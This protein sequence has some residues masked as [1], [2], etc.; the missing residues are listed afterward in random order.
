MYQQSVLNVSHSLANAL[1]LSTQTSP[2]GA[3]K[4]YYF[5]CFMNGD[6]KCLWEPRSQMHRIWFLRVFSHL[7][8][9]CS[10][11]W[12]CTMLKLPCVFKWR[13]SQMLVGSL[14]Q[15]SM[16][17]TSRQQ[18]L[19][20]RPLSHGCGRG[21]KEAESEFSVFLLVNFQRTELSWT[22]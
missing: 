1:H 16:L 10:L 11:R 5:P 9:K 14:A 18:Y 3:C 7:Y 13:S 20:S 8:S 15:E 17:G 4:V 19:C 6:P 2:W 12:Y 21:W 22:F